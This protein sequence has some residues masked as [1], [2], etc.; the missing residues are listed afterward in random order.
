VW[1]PCGLGGPPGAATPP[2]STPAAFR[3]GTA[4]TASEKA[5]S[6]IDL[7]DTAQNRLEARERTGDS[8]DKAEAEADYAV[9]AEDA[10]PA[11][12]RFLDAV[13]VVLARHRAPL[14]RCYRPSVLLGNRQV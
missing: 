2:C 6:L 10:R 7:L 9:A 1:S 12:Q 11:Y 4:L 14:R 8:T 3:A 5:Q 13:A